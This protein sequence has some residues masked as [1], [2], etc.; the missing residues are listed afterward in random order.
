MN[1]CVCSIIAENQV[2]IKFGGNFF[3][4]AQAPG[5]S[6]T[7]IVYCSMRGISLTIGYCGPDCIPG[8]LVGYEQVVAGFRIQGIHWVVGIFDNRS[9]CF[10]DSIF[11]RIFSGHESR[12]GESG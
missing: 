4:I 8:F 12:P 3:D 11:Y 5:I 1:G 9:N 2:E 6:I 7:N 10:V